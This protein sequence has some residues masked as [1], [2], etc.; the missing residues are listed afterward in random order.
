MY[1]LADKIIVVI[2]NIH[3]SEYWQDTSTYAI[4]SRF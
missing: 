4:D 1:T 3:F 2:S